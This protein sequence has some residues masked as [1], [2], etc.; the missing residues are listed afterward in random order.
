IA[1]TAEEVGKA[2][3]RLQQIGADGHRMLSALEA[4]A[5]SAADRERFKKIDSSFQDY[6]AVLHEFVEQ[7]SQILSLFGSLDQIYLKSIR[8]VTQA[9]NSSPFANL[10]NYSEVEGY[11]NEAVS[12]FKDARAAAWRFFVLHEELQ[13]RRISASADQA[14]QKLQFARR[15]IGDPA[16]VAEV[17]VLLAIVPE[18]AGIL[19]ATTDTIDLQ[20]RLQLERA[21][22]AEQETRKLLDEATATANERSDV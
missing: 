9:V 19:K 8:S 13:I 10:A 1:R 20:N 15:T 17:D 3:D 7:Q 11:I 5:D 21:N 16:L 14:T 18:Y 4:R 22:P 6:V 12:A 2:L